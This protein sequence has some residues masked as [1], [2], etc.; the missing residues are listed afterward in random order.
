[1]NDLSLD[2][3][4]QLLSQHFHPATIE[5]AEWFKFLKRKQKEDESTTEYMG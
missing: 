5:I 1:M 4:V 3:I 2:A